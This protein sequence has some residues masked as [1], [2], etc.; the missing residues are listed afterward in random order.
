MIS[1]LL[2]LLM[3]FLSLGQT[4]VDSY[5]DQMSLGGNLFLINRDYMISADYEPDDLVMPAVKRTS[6][7]VMMRKEAAEALEALFSAAKSEKKYTLVAVSGYR[8]YGTQNSIYNRKVKNVG[9]KKANL[10]VA[11][12]GA[13]EHQLGLAMDVGCKSS[14]GLNGSFG[15]LPEGKWLAENCYRFGFIIRYK[16]EWTETTG[17]AYEPWHIRYVGVEHALKIKE[18]DIPLED[19][20]SYLLKAQQMLSEET[21]KE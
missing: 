20:V 4:T 2:S 17:Y 3:V 21:E 1:K 8:S 13:S 14:T 7:S 19:Y 11:L 18:L 9:K 15:S 6:S 16:A 5:V 12:P 10:L